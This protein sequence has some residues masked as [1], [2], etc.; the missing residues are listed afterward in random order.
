M[1]LLLTS[2]GVDNRTIA[3][4]LHELTGK[5]P[6][7]TKV[8]FVPTA[9]N[10]EQ[11]NKDWFINQF[12]KL[13]RFGYNWV[14]VVDPSANNVDWKTRLNECDVI[15]ISGGNTFH[16]LDQARKSGFD[17]WLEDNKNKKVFVGSSA[18][19]LFLTP[20]IEIA[21]LEPGPDINLCGITDLTAMG[22]VDFEVEPH[23][24][25]ARFKVV[26]TY[27]KKK[28]NPVYAIDDQT[29]IKIDD[30]K[31]EVVT[32]GSWELFE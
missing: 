1:K 28:N 26:E 27:A 8:G 16:L 20:T 2:S 6:G 21:G 24:N 14:D 22:W 13:W 9:A 19:T 11:G 18:G 4:A 30:D 7:D 3:K 15:F 31:V 10:A 32:E 25:Q 23:C 12:V 29:A 17:K 5:L